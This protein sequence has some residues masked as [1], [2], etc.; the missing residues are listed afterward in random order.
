[1][2]FIDKTISIF[3]PAKAFKRVTARKMLAMADSSFTGASKTKRSMKRWNFKGTQDPDEEIIPEL[4]ELR[5][6]SRDLYK[7]NP[8]ASG[9]IKTA[10]T[11]IIGSGLRLQARIDREF[12]NMMD[13]EADKW[14]TNVERQ[15]RFW[16]ENNDADAG[17]RLNFYEIQELAFLSYL[18]SGD[19]FALLPLINRKGTIS[20]LKIQLVESDRVCNER[21]MPDN[22]NVAGGIEVGAYCE[23]IAYWILSKPIS[24]YNYKEEWTKISAFGSQSGRQ[25]VIHLYRQERP[26]QRRGVPFLSPVIETLH[27]L[28]KYTD[29]ELMGSLI[30]SMFTVFVK[31][32]NGNNDILGNAFSDLESTKDDTKYELGNGAIVGLGENEDVVFANPA[33]PNVQFDAFV[34]SLLRQVGMALEIPYELLIRHFQSSYSASRAALLEAWKF[35][36]VRRTWMASKF[37]QP[38][39]EEFLIDAILNGRISAPGFFDSIEIRRAYTGA[40]WIGPSAGQIDPVKETKAA[41]M[42][43]ASGYTTYAEETAAL[44]GGDWERKIKQR[45]KEER[46][47][48]SLGLN[49]VVEA[50]NN[51]KSTNQE[52]IIEQK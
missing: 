49:P 21:H 52:Q 26:A 41:D 36:R 5:A 3:D 34:Q 20:I 8:I 12:L 19:V 2:N 4:E 44:V 7:N 39:Y 1:M 24:S 25:N 40:E 27:M 9:A 46:Q 48:E 13:D 42:R 35:F 6:R 17:R 50:N 32:V 28:G 45:A 23:P 31:T 18:Q 30:S 37:C 22:Q 11:N 38:I 10:L 29:S 15:F 51:A 14:E 16:A 33:R 43:V 47:K